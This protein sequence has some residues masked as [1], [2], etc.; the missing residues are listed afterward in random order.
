MLI[1][2]E[3]ISHHEPQLAPIKTGAAR[4]A[5]SARDERG[6]H[7]L[8]IVPVGLNFEDKASPRTRVLVLNKA[9]LVEP[10]RYQPLVGL[11]SQL[12]VPTLLTSARTGV[13]IEALRK[14]LRGFHPAAGLLHVALDPRQLR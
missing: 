9:D 6:I 11:Y 8:R 7:D 2:P 5:L 4:I 13:G 1:F 3:G 14:R 10:A 12:G